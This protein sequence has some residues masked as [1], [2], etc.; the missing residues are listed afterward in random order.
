M[1]V[2]CYNPGLAIGEITLVGGPIAGAVWTRVRRTFGC[3]PEPA[4]DPADGQAEPSRSHASPAQATA[5]A[6]A[7]QMNA[8]G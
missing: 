4:E 7:A 5:A 6:A 1:C 3:A 8:T 2:F